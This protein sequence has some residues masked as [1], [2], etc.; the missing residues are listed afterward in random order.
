MKS[1][2]IQSKKESDLDL[3]IEL[4]NR[5]GLKT[6][7]ILDEEQEETALLSAMDS[8]STELLTES[9]KANFLKSL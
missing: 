7:I 6:N 4:S 1:I 3:L 8:E 2:L 9:E 5:L